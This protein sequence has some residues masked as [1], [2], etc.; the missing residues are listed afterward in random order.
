MTNAGT[1]LDRIEAVGIVALLA[2]AL[3]IAFPG[4]D[5][6][7]SRLFG[8]VDDFPLRAS[9]AWNAVRDAMIG[10]SDGAMLV[11]IAMLLA[12]LVWPG[13]QVLR[14]RVLAFAV[15]SYAL[16]PGLLVNAV[17]KSH[18][19][20]PR[21]WNVDLFGGDAVFSPLF[22]F[23]GQC[24]WHCS[25]VSGEASALATMATI[26]L[27]VAVP[28]LPRRNRVAARIGIVAVAV[29]GSLLRVAFGAHFLSDVVFAWL[30]SVPLVL[31]LHAAF[32]IGRLN[33]P[34]ATTAGVPA[35]RLHDRNLDDRHALS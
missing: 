9:V 28:L 4:L 1:S 24:H 31:A 22:D 21:P 26:L 3:F 16:G 18:S 29:A 23:A 11:V 17:L 32:G 20:H 33:T 30:G 6:A 14:T 25:F 15:A 10:L 12:G 27:L 34:L 35:R 13:C 19:G 5:L 8:G 2:S 7:I